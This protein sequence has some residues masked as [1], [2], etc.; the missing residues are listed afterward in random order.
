MLLQLIMLYLLRH[1]PARAEARA[2]VSRA[3]AEPSRILHRGPLFGSHAPR[4]GRPRAPRRVETR[5]EPS[6]PEEGSGWPPPRSGRRNDNGTNNNYDSSNNNN[7][8]NNNEPSG[9]PRKQPLRQP[10]GRFEVPLPGQILRNSDITFCSRI[11]FTV[12]FGCRHGV[13]YT[14]LLQWFVFSDSEESS[15]RTGSSFSFHCQCSSK[16]GA[17][18]TTSILA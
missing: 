4:K 18:E 15:S 11:S 9:A 10:P 8:N 16:G 13:D 6:E 2:F 3:R 14:R 12:V 1:T 7:S 17:T 5:L